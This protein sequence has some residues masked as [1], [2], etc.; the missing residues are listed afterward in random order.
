MYYAPGYIARSK[1]FLIGGQMA[2]FYLAV[3][4]TVGM[5]WWKLLGWC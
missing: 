1:W 4:F 2:L 5:G 3:Y